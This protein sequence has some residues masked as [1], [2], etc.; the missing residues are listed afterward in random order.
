MSGAARRIVAVDGPAAS[1]K[2][3]LARRLAAHF[4]LDFLDT[5]LLYR[6]V[7]WKLLQ[8][9]RPFADTERAIAAARA[10]T[11][12][13]LDPLTL[14]SDAIGQGASVVAAIPEVRQAL[15]GIQRRFGNGGP[16]AVLAGRDIGTVV[17][18]DASHKIFV[19]A[20]AQE[21]ARRRCQEL[22]ALGVPTIYDEVLAK[23]Q[24]RDA[25]DRW[26]AVAPLAPAGD[27]FVI[28]TTDQD[29]ETAFAIA[30]AY[31]AGCPRG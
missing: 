22:Q 12:A 21:R 1:G 30:R 29:I 31:V 28:D 26:R 19:T 18:P 5:G 9:G 25:R 17:R 23:L 13:D 14:R 7:A 27:A 4:G 15:L 11:A 24:E 20:S 8:A 2:T 16:G 6:A 3:T 10:V